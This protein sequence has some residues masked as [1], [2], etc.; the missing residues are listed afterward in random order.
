MEDCEVAMDLLSF[1]LYH[2]GDNTDSAR[3]RALYLPFLS[4]VYSRLKLLVVI[5]CLTREL[6]FLLL[7]MF[8]L[9]LP[10]PEARPRVPP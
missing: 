2:E 6:T 4:P 7:C 9:R 5:G 8:R 10:R 3:V 1:A